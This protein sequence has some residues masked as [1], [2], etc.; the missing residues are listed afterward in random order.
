MLLQKL[1]K[2]MVG[3]ALAVPRATRANSVPSAEVP[4]LNFGIAL[5]VQR[6]IRVNS[7]PNAEHPSPRHGIVPIVEPKVTK[8][9]SVRSAVKPVK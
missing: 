6:A 7:V 5:A 1:L 4:S 3:N 2:L 9:S 8:V